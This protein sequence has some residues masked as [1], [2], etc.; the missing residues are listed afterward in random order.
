MNL[1]IDFVETKYC[2]TTEPDNECIVEDMENAYDWKGYFFAGLM[3]ATTICQSIILNQYFV[4]MYIVSMNIR[5]A[6]ISA[7]YRKAL[8][9]SNSARKESTVGEIVNLMSVDVQRFMVRWNTFCP[10]WNLFEMYQYYG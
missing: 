4:R 8:V 9:M 3:L 10:V 5:T 6:L 7:I 1:M 2:D